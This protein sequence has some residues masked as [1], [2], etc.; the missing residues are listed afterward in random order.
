[1]TDVL[2]FLDRRRLLGLLVGLPLAGRAE[3]AYAM[4]AALAS[5][6]FSDPATMLIAGPEGATLDRWGHVLAPALAQSLAPETALRRSA[7]GAPDGVTG[8]NQF[9]ARAAPDGETVLLAPGEAVLAWLVGD[10]RAQYDVARWISVMVALSSGIVMARPGA[11][12]PGQ[13]IRLPTTSLAGVDLPA[14]LGLELLGM[15]IEQAPPLT[16]DALP[17]AMAQGSVD[18][19]F[20]RGHKVAGQARALAAAGAQPVFAL[21]ALDPNG[22][23]ARSPAFPDV[24]TLAE[25]YPSMQG[26]TLGGPLYTAWCAAAV[27]SQ[28]EF[29]LVLPQLTPAAMVSL[30]RRASG[31]AV[32]ALDV[33]SLAQAMGVRALGGSEATATAG[34]TAADQASLL[35]LR[36]WLTARFNWKPA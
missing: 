30:W 32:G 4:R 12:V 19:V 35:A 7:M 29:V 27:A 13:R 1:M 31:E 8:A 22:R 33:Q 25:R 5:P 26:Q 16:D 28:L 3:S 6:V 21:G 36:G 9:G 15:R 11:I 20:L 18:A 24:P 10:P 14:A 17:R 34:A 23:V 2:P